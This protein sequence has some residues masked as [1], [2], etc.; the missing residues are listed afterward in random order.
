[1]G[2]GGGAPLRPQSGMGEVTSRV[3]PIEREAALQTPPQ[4]GEARDPAAVGR[5][6]VA[7]VQ[8]VAARQTLQREIGERRA[9]LADREPR[10]CA[11]LEQG[12]VMSLD[13][14]DAGEQRAGKAAADDR[15]A[16]AVQ[17]TGGSG[18]GIR[19]MRLS[20]STR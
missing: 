14:E 10:V 12:D 16:H 6:I 17:G 3:V 7:I 5:E 2:G 1:G 15:Y 20:R 18:M 11:A 19:F 8:T 9:R 13:R 4:L